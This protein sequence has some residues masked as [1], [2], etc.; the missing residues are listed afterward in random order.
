MDFIT[1]KAISRRKMLRGTG[2][3][4]AL[5][6]LDAML[7]ARVLGA[8]RSRPADSPA[9][10]FLVYYTP[11]GQ[12]MPHW[13]PN[14]EGRDFELSEILEPLQPFKD[15]MIVMSG[16][17]GSWSQQHPGASTCFLTGITDGPSDASYVGAKTSIDQIL[18]R[19]FA[20][21]TQ[22]GSLELG[23][24]G[25]PVA[26]ACAVLNCAYTS[27]ISWRGPTQPLPMENHPRIVFETLFGDAGTTERGPRERRLLQRKSILD[28]VLE[29]LGDL[30]R[31][32]G[33]QDQ[34]KVDQY[35]DSVRDVERR[36][37]VAEDRIDVE[38]P[39][40]SQP[41]GIPDGIEQHLELLLDLQ[42]LAF[43]ADLT[44]VSTFMVGSETNARSYSH[45]GV[46]EAWHPLSH[47]RNIP[48]MV[49]R[50]AIINRYHVE[51]FARYVTKLQETPDGD[52]SL[53]DHMTILY[54]SGISNSQAHSNNNLPLL[55]LGGGN[56]T[57]NGG[58]H[59][60]YEGRP[61]N[62]NL[63]V[64]LMDKLGVPVDKVGGSTGELL[65]DTLPG[66]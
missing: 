29:Q 49:A 45:I 59:L 21:E 38:L 8:A 7:P 9:H 46:P 31:E 48:E 36:I 32:L 24:D 15:Q 54:G 1:G 18:A 27:T 17:E 56:G 55:L 13:T 66:V 58:Q 64:T 47:H 57:L 25:P 5:P 65:I 12:A 28:S 2:V 11:N 34:L 53:L 60:V 51:L 6:F 37:Q 44:R 39:A 43:Q 61:S 33:A 22:L 30:K 35:L 16:I 26:G 42:L 41:P 10:R 3:G 52:G 19:E 20:K 62:A 63:L 50:L 23:L 40:M 4:L 14:G